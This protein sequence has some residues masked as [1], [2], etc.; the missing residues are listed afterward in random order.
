MDLLKKTSYYSMKHQKDLL[1]PATKLIEKI[2]DAS[3]TKEYHQSCLKNKNK[4]AV[5]WSKLITQQPK[6]LESP[7]II[8]I[9]SVT[10]EHPKNFKAD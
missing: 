1:M 7:N 4:K 9:K 10:I 6:T 8:D 5:K 3:N 2:Q